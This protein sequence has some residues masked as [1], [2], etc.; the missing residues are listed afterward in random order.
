MTQGHRNDSDESENVVFLHGKSK[1][2]KNLL[3]SSA[4]STFSN[5]FRPLF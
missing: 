5:N 2:L 4:S 3:K 1:G